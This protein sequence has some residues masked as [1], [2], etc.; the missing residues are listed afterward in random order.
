MLKLKSAFV[1]IAIL[2]S[3]CG[4]VLA[5]DKVVVTFSGVSSEPVDLH[6]NII[7][8]YA[9]PFVNSFNFKAVLPYS[10]VLTVPE[11]ASVS[12]GSLYKHPYKI[13]RNGK[14]CMEVISMIN[15]KPDAYMCPGKI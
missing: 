9:K 6:I 7:D 5:Q 1:A 12:A 14:L 13:T 10:R 15:G 4:S 11:K 2:F 3:N 8:P